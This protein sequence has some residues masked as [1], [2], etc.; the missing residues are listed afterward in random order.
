MVTEIFIPATNGIMIDPNIQYSAQRTLG[1]EKRSE[2]YGEIV[3][4]Q[5]KALHDYKLQPTELQIT[6][7]DTLINMGA[8][9]IINRT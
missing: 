4:V 7:Y 9:H 3:K 1:D 2:I 5:K 8:Y 6:R